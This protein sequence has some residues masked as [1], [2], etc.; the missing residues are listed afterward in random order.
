MNEY[1]PAGN[2]T[3]EGSSSENGLEVRSDPLT[4][5][6]DRWEKLAKSVRD[7]RS[8]NAAL[9]EQLQGREDSVGRVEREL[10]AKTAELAALHEEKRRMD[11]RIGGLLAR[12]DEIGP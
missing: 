2:Q 4:E 7:L 11:G 6:E 8:E 10:A 5:L 3:T 12:F 9:W 1:S